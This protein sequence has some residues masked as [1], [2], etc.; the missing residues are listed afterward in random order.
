M[1]HSHGC[2]FACQIIHV[3]LHASEKFGYAAWVDV[4]RG[5]RWRVFKEEFSVVFLEVPFTARVTQVGSTLVFRL[6]DGIAVEV[7][8]PNEDTVF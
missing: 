8:T 4:I 3:Q 7:K 1:A 6:D 5:T 2:T